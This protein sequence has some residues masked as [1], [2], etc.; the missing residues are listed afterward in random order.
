MPPTP[1]KILR[2][3]PLLAIID[4]SFTPPW[5]PRLPLDSPSPTY[6]QR[7]NQGRLK[8]LS[9]GGGGIIEK[10]FESFFKIQNQRTLFPHPVFQVGE[11]PPIFPGGTLHPSPISRYGGAC[12]LVYVYP[13]DRSVARRGVPCK[14]TSAP[15]FS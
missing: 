9:M 13:P 11:S 1:T 10:V 5:N 4:G 6:R 3:T 2:N 15:P 8:I 7:H 12:N 14:G